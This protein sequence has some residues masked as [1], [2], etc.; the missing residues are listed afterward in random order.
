MGGRALPLPAVECDTLEEDD[1]CSAVL[2][3]GTLCKGSCGG[4]VAAPIECDAGA[5][6]AD[7]LRTG[8]CDPRGLPGLPAAVRGRLTP[9]PPLLPCAGLCCWVALPP[10]GPGLELPDGGRGGD[11]EFRTLTTR[12]DKPSGFGHL[13][14]FSL[15]NSSPFLPRP[16]I[17]TSKLPRRGYRIFSLVPRWM[18]IVGTDEEVRG[19]N[20]GG[21]S[22]T[23]AMEGGRIVTAGSTQ[24]AY[25]K[26]RRPVTS[27]HQ[28][29]TDRGKG[30][31]TY[32]R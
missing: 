10:R 9:L 25:S 20:P 21:G 29:R 28:K 5:L 6:A 1:T 14:D 17:V 31:P 15:L 3:A 12:L 32:C 18:Y 8:D 23:T 13:R 2:S 11:R 4:F 7:A 19:T 27:A 26:G 30:T 24:L 16:R 22:V